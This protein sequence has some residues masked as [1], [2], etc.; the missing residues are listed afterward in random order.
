MI[1]R[2]TYFIV[3]IIFFAG[4]FWILSQPPQT[5]TQTT[6]QN[7]ND[8]YKDYPI[9]D[10]PDLIFYW[11]DGCPHCENVE[12]WLTEN[13][14]DNKLKIN[15]K[16]V[17]DNKNNQTEFYNT[18]KQYCSEIIDNGNI[19]VPTGFDPVSQKCIQ[20]DTPIIGFLS[21]KLTK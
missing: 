2:V 16:E 6:S 21:D 19:G 10:N 11:G 3:A 8:I 20:G 7:S 1:K 14:S 9:Y 13:N 18:A 4:L 17:Y 12:K 5:T 15:Y